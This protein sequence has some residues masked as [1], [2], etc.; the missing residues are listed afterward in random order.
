M[1]DWIATFIGIVG[2]LGASAAHA[3]GD[4]VKGSG[5]F[6]HPC[7]YDRDQLCTGIDAGARRVG[8]RP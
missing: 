7:D 2:L 6:K 3:Q 5:V 1:L 4:S 8:S